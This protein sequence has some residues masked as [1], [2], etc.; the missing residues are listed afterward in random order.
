ML[1]Q[2]LVKLYEAWAEKGEI[3]KLGWEPVGISYGISL[4]EEGNV[5]E[6][7][8]LKT[9][10]SNGNTTIPSTIELPKDVGKTSGVTSNFLYEKATY[11]FRSEE[12]R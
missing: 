11:V 3:E 2:S 10:S 8:N 9:K 12:R 6:I 1:L 7:I 5:D 4:D